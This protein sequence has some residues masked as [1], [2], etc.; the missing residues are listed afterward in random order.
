[1]EADLREKIRRLAPEQLAVYFHQYLHCEARLVKIQ[2][3]IG[4]SSAVLVSDG[5]VDGHATVEPKGLASFSPSWDGLFSPTLNNFCFQ[6]KAGK[7]F[8]PT[9]TKLKEELLVKDKAGVESLK[10]FVKERL[11]RPNSQYVLV[12]S[13]F[14]ELTTK[15]KTKVENDIFEILSEHWISASSRVIGT[16]SL[17]EAFGRHSSIKGQILW[18]RST[19]LVP[20]DNNDFGFNGDLI[21]SSSGKALENTLDSFYQDSVNCGESKVFAICWDEGVWKSRFIRDYLR[22]SKI[23]ALYGRSEH[24]ATDDL[25]RSYLSDPDLSWTVVI[26]DCDRKFLEFV[27][28]HKKSF[29]G[30]GKA[31]ILISGDLELF[32][33]GDDRFPWITFWRLEPLNEQESKQLLNKVYGVLEADMDNYISIADGIPESLHEIGKWVRSG[34]GS[35]I[36]SLRKSI[37]EILHGKYCPDRTYSQFVLLS[38][39]CGSTSKSNPNIEAFTGLMELVFGEKFHKAFFY[40]YIDRLWRDRGI[41]SSKTLKFRRY[42]QMALI[43]HFFEL[44]PDCFHYSFISRTPLASFFLKWFSKFNAFRGEAY[45]SELYLELV[46]AADEFNSETI[47]AEL[48][49]ILHF[50]RRKALD[51]LLAK[52]WEFWKLSSKTLTELGE[53]VRYLTIWKTTFDVAFDLLLDL[54]SLGNSYAEQKLGELFYRG[55]GEHSKT[56]VSLLKRVEKILDRLESEKNPH[57]QKRLAKALENLSVSHWASPIHPYSIGLE[58]ERPELWLPKTYWDLFGEYLLIAEKLLEILKKNVPE[59]E[60]ISKIPVSLCEHMAGSFAYAK[61]IDFLKRCWNEHPELLDEIL[62]VSRKMAEWPH[63]EKLRKEVR[64]AWK[65]FYSEITADFRAYYRAIIATS[66]SEDFFNRRGNYRETPKTFKSLLLTISKSPNLFIE[67]A[68]EFMSITWYKS[69]QFASLLWSMKS[70]GFLVDPIMRAFVSSPNETL[71]FFHSFFASY[72]WKFNKAGRKILSFIKD[73]SSINGFYPQMLSAF[74]GEK[75]DLFS[76][77]LDGIE[78]WKFEVASL[79]F[80]QSWRRISS[81]PLEEVGRI[82]DC[83]KGNPELLSVWSDLLYFNFII[84]SENPSEVFTG[85]WVDRIR[86]FLFQ[87]IGSSRLHWSDLYHWEELLK[88]FL[89]SQ[90]RYVG[91]AIDFLLDIYWASGSWL[92]FRDSEVISWIFNSF[93]VEVLD[94]V[95]S[96]LEDEHRST[97]TMI[98]L[99]K[100]SQLFDARDQQFDDKVFS[101]I[102][103]FKDERLIEV[104]DMCSAYFSPNS[105][106]SFSRK[107]LMRYGHAPE[108]SRAFQ[109]HAVE[110]WSWSRRDYYQ[111]RVVEFRKQF[112]EEVHP[113]VKKHFRYL[114]ELQEALAIRF[115]NDDDNDWDD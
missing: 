105:E 14:L 37:Q 68:V 67:H 74:N 48:I 23:P 102:D 46:S 21:E 93:P 35:A 85:V 19:G 13:D 38:A 99:V 5:G 109:S 18:V 90:S 96:R 65:S 32:N 24:M 8:N 31:I 108:L 94:K 103:S 10:P 82:L 115:R 62:D 41:K 70:A 86:D 114:Q 40:Y 72:S 61:V 45:V 52:R 30:N 59:R 75:T 44:Y 27:A 4:I 101:W 55:F 25:F 83:L 110:S 66:Y 15:K 16:D 20:I 12:I 26:D 79:K 60:L 28:S 56:E 7:N 22:K 29:I 17:C 63:E 97:Y 112:E 87:D 78:S 9:T 88:K 2:A 95:F 47:S 6:L 43:K 42:D 3:D 57:A 34:K 111:T 53:A 89:E 50:D 49:C 69:T 11:N 36:F 64:D 39:V 84:D 98:Y 80:F 76:E 107:L 106:T 92:Y 104:A 71:A 81:L 100:E 51:L 54:V 1:M 33:E 113:E 73:T 77:Y 91:D 58:N